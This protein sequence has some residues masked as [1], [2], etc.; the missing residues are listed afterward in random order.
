[1][2]GWT[3]FCYSFSYYVPPLLVN[4]SARVSGQVRSGF[5]PV[6]RGPSMGLYSLRRSGSGKVQG[7]VCERC[8][9]TECSY[10]SRRRP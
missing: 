3:G 6:T 4:D 9:S 8:V 1:M 10:R 2:R 7:E 5:T